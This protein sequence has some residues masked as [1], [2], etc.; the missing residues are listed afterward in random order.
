MIAAQFRTLIA[1]LNQADCRYLVVGGFAVVAHG[2]LRLTGDI[3]L[4]LDL[5]E[6]VAAGAVLRVLETLGYRPRAPVP[7]TDYL[8]PDKRR[9]WR[10]EKD[11]V[12]FSAYG[13]G[14]YGATLDLFLET[15]FPFKPAWEERTDLDIGSG[16][17]AHFVDFS[18]LCA[19]KEQAGRPK[20]LDDLE[21]LRRIHDA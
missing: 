7:W 1:A 18:R 10:D 17:I 14:P 8:D 5:E 19:M 15:P 13:S 11:M 12:V 16:V 9:R 4:V 3:D 21:N 2:Y 6:P 20:D